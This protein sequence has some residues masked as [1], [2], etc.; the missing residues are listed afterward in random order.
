MFPEG[1]HGSIRRVHASPH[2]T[3]LLPMTTFLTVRFSR[4][5]RMRSQPSGRTKTWRSRTC[6]G[7]LSTPESL[8][9]N[10]SECGHLLTPSMVPLILRQQ[11]PDLTTLI[12]KKSLHW[13]ALA[14]TG[15]L[16]TRLALKMKIVLRRGQNFRKE[17]LSTGQKNTFVN[18]S[19]RRAS[20]CRWMRLANVGVRSF[21]STP[22][23]R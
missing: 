22:Y 13:L 12:A 16:L 21:Q 2:R 23:F 5:R 4:V 6:K 3:A 20:R 15:C 18:C 10:G 7:F 14:D 9:L 11:G 1:A 19:L 17:S 8:P